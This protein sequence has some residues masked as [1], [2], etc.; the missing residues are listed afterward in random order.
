ML[1]EVSD[2]FLNISH[3]KRIL[4]LNISILPMH[5]K[6]KFLLPGL[7]VIGIWNAQ[8]SFSQKNFSPGYVI[9]LNGDTIKGYVDSK[10]RNVNPGKIDFKLKKDGMPIKYSPDDIKEFG[11]RDEIYVSAMV[12][13]EV[14]SDEVAI[15]DQDPELKI[16][17]HKVFLQTLFKGDK[18]LYYY[19]SSSRKDNFYIKQDTIIELLRHKKYVLYDGNEHRIVENKK[20]AAQLAQYLNNC[21]YILSEIESTKYTYS[22]I[23]KLFISYYDCSQSEILFRKKIKQASIEKGVLF[24]ASIS[25]LDFSGSAL[26]YLIDTDF[27][28]STD[29]SAGVFTDLIISGHQGRWS[30]NNDLIFTTLSISGQHK[31][32]KAA[33]NYTIHTTEFDLSYIK[34]H[35]LLRY[36]YPVGK[37]SLFANIGMSNGF[38]V[39]ESTYSRQEIRL[40]SSENTVEGKALD[41]IRKLEQGIVFGAGTKYNK[42]SFEI[43]YERGNGISPYAYLT[44]TSK[45]YYFML[46]Y[47]F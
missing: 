32:I 10:N 28:F 34:M 29:I 12:E 19:K 43:R 1:V 24:G 36:S 16:E 15:K 47:R 20:Y 13:T 26:D 46:G 40:Y 22:S 18:Y 5:T 27:N 37:V 23:E 14:S 42:L 38:I 17:V 30:I 45:R 41:K 2:E 21:P 31:D 25:S 11:V 9:N 35:N 7:I 44:S 6:M 4:L 8:P 3:N 39:S 33:E